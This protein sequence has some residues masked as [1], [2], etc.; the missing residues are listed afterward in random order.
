M[1][2]KRPA[3]LGSGEMLARLPAAR[4]IQQRRGAAQPVSAVLSPRPLY[5]GRTG[6]S[7]GE[8]C[9]TRSRDHT[10]NAITIRANCDDGDDDHADDDA[11]ANGGEHDHDA[12]DGR[13]H[14][15]RI[16]I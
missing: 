15:E 13:D 11:D 4:I 5:T 16:E 7:S 6:A 3:S 10:N 1:H 8:R 2:R 12:N 9:K 14:A